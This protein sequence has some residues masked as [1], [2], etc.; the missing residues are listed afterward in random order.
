VTGDTYQGA[1][2]VSFRQPF[3]D[4]TVADDV[5]RL[6]PDAEGRWRWFFGRSREFVNEQI[7]RYS[8]AGP[9]AGDIGRVASVADDLDAFWHGAFGSAQ[10]VYVTPEIVRADEP[11]VGACGIFGPGRGAA[12]CGLDQT[13]YYE[14]AFFAAREATIGDFAWKVVLAHEWGH[15]VQILLGIQWT[16]GNAFE[17][18]ADCLAGAYARDAGTRG[19]LDPGDITE[20]VTGSAAAGDPFGLPQD[21][22]GAH[23]TSDERITAFMRGYLD[24]FL[25]C[26][27]P[28]DS[29]T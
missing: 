14:G 5:G 2:E 27:L 26:D 21:Q 22:P 25:G 20:A 16:A 23:G 10:Q 6:V 12:Y 13:I 28:V 15:H 17:L 24:G 8:P 11:I 3:E 7:A 1:A 18:Q 29:D 19:W 9:E 4:G